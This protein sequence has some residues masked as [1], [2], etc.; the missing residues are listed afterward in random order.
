M[1]FACGVMSFF[2]L[3]RASLGIKFF[4]GQK[5][6]KFGMTLN[7]LCSFV[8]RDTTY[9]PLQNSNAMV[10]HYFNKSHTRVDYDRG[11]VNGFGAVRGVV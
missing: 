3:F 1:G 2:V 4:G 11:P 10:T 6:L 9:N 8:L 7:F 5:Q